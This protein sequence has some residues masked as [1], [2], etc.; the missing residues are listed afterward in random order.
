MEGSIIGFKRLANHSWFDFS[1]VFAISH[2]T[3][4]NYKQSAAIQTLMTQVKYNVTGG[5]TGLD[6][7]ACALLIYNTKL[8]NKLAYGKLYALKGFLVGA[9]R[10]EMPFFM[11]DID[12][13]HEVPE[14]YPKQDI[15]IRSLG[16]VDKPLSDLDNQQHESTISV[17]V[18]HDGVNEDDEEDQSILVEYVVPWNNS[19]KTF[20]KAFTV[21]R[22]VL[23]C[24]TLGGWSRRL[25]MMSVKVTSWYLHDGQVGK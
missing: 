5:L 19:A 2:T 21:G 24:G 11:C 1:G 18:R 8:S 12:G 13:K 4:E 7:H 3:V 14:N 20:S 16:R 23:F 9:K 17:V 10:H 15:Q 22:Q 6:D 25:D